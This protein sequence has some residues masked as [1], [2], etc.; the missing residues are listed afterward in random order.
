MEET[1]GYC[2]QVVGWNYPWV[3]QMG[4]S[5]VQALNSQLCICMWLS[6]VLPASAWGQFGT[7]RQNVERWQQDEGS[8]ICWSLGVLC[9]HDAKGGLWIH[10]QCG[11]PGFDPWIEKTPWRREQLSTPASL[12]GEL[13]GQGNLAAAVHGVEESRA[14]LTD[15]HCRGQGLL[16]T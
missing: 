2:P 12:P 10:L 13:H 6:C 7:K 14:R 16:K 4:L 11:K 8:S 3:K 15:F 9:V 5:R 1:Q